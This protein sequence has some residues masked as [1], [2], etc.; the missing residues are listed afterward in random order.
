MNIR[1][2]LAARS[3]R[4]AGSPGEEGLPLWMMKA[5]DASGWFGCLACAAWAH[6]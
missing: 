4:T 2:C 1:V 3:R 6:R 5:T